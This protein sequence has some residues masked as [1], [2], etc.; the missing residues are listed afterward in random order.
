MLKREPEVI[1]CDLHCKTCA[2]RCCGT[3]EYGFLASGGPDCLVVGCYAN[4]VSPEQKFPR[5]RP[6]RP[7]DA[8]V[9][10]PK[11]C[12]KYALKRR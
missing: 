5:K 9:S 11:P 8:T 3:C 1:S 4:V 2:L 10:P 12:E 7:L 6:I